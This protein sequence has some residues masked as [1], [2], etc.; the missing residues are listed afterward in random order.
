MYAPVRA[1]LAT[2][3]L[4]DIPNDDATRRNALATRLDI[5]FAP[6]FWVKNS[7]ETPEMTAM[8]V[9]PAPLRYAPCAPA[10]YAASII[11]LR[12]GYAAAPRC[13]WWMR[14]SIP[15]RSISYRP[16]ENACIIQA[17]RPILNTASF[18]GTC[19][20]TTRRSSVMPVKSGTNMININPS[21]NLTR[22]VVHRSSL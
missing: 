13:G 17:S 4:P 8:T 18:R 14:S 16:D 9:G 7:A 6:F 5:C 22:S 21:C 2:N 19:F 20:G 15:M 11:G 10:A 12:W 3:T 1:G